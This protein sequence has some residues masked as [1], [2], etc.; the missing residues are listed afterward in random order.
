MTMQCTVY[1]AGWA[2]VIQSLGSCL[3][4]GG[5]IQ[6]L[7]PVPAARVGGLAVVIQSLDPASLR[8]A[9]CAGRSYPE[10]GSRPSGTRGG[11]ARR[12]SIQS[13]DPVSGWAVVSRAWIPSQPHAWGAWQLVSRAWILPC[14]ACLGG[15][16]VV[17]QSLDPVTAAPVVSLTFLD[18]EPG[19]RL[20]GPPLCFDQ[21]D[22]S[23]GP[24]H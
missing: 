14:W 19:S 4:L 18:P 12:S 13:L 1:V 11:G 17:I 15:L 2:V 9:C 23:T 20:A 7:D 6:S 3:G 21:L 24:T 10:P 16:A 8:R 22:G 5:G